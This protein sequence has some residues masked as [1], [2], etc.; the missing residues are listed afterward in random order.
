[1]RNFILLLLFVFTRCSTA[2][3]IIAS[4][5]DAPRRDT[6]N[7]IVDAHDGRVVQFGKKFYWYGTRYGNTN[8]FTEVNAY[9]CY[10]SFNLVQW[11][12]E[13]E[14]LPK[15]PTGVYYRPHVVYN[16]KT[17]KY[18]LW[19]NW[20]PK[21]WNGQFGVAESNSPVGPFTI[22]NYNVSVKHSALG[23]GDLGLFVDND[24]KAYLSYNTIN[25]HKVSVELLDESYTASTKKGSEFMAQNSEAGSMFKRNNTYYL[26]TDYT[27]CFCT[28]GSGARVYTA[29]NP[30]GPYTFRQNM[31]RYP[32]QLVPLLKDGNISDNFF[33][34]LQAKEQNALEMWMDARVS[35]SSLT[36]HQFTGN[37]NGQ[38]GE[39][40]NPVVH[41]PIEQ[42]AFDVQYFDEGEWK[43]IPAGNPIIEAGSMTNTY[44]YQFPALKT[45]RIKIIPCIRIALHRFI[46]QKLCETR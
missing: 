14:I 27:C 32:G 39:V 12:Y 21:L 26:L 15:R 18:I 36:I 8:G 46:F 29:N 42:F 44:R 5:N 13:G 22:S 19:Y 40:D 34:T 17:K 41:E 37:R 35:V 24:D 23:V 45:E 38:C 10:S 20:Y 7:N 9:V 33:E 43:A 1:M 31:N 6:D 4:N 25:G 3:T 16:K 30:L 28:Q 2:Q 11:K